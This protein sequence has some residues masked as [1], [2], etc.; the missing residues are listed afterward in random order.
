[1]QRTF[2][3][4]GRFYRVCVKCNKSKPL[5]EFGPAKSKYKG[6]SY[7]CIK[8]NKRLRNLHISC[9]Y[10]KCT[11]CGK[12]RPLR[13]FYVHS[14]SR[15]GRQSRCITCAKEDYLVR[16]KSRKRYKR[17][18]IIPGKL[19]MCSRCGKILP[20]TG[21]Y[22]FFSCRKWCKTCRGDYKRERKAIV[23]N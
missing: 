23:F 14:G 15:N 16:N 9:G 2:L 11:R 21:D 17:L 19:R 10:S 4:N 7:L 12:I 8:C 6:R 20:D 22:F 13:S 3:K 5:R 18:V 1:M